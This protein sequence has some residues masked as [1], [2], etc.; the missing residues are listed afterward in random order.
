ML[1]ALLLAVAVA[2][3]A[4]APSA[5]PLK[6][7]TTVKSGPIC[8]TL[9]TTVLHT[10]QGL[11]INDKIIESSKP[12]L[13]DMAQAWAPNSL[14]GEKFDQLQAQWGNAPAGTH[15][16]D[17]AGLILGAQHIYK[18]ATGLVHN[19]QIIDNL[20]DDPARFPADPKTDVDRE[21]ALLKAQLQSVADQQRK[22]LNVLYGMADTFNMQ[23]LIAHGDGT[24]GAINAGGKNGQVS[25]ND[26]DVSFQDP[27]SGPDRGR[28]GSPKDPTVDTDPAISQKSLGALANSP[29]MRFY[30]G[31][32]EEQQATAQAEGDLSQTVIQVVN[33]CK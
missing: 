17:N 8:S 28:I 1:Q 23:D 14:A 4:P 32:V 13:V 5:S 31:V 12:V 18:V 2:Q 24:Q 30:T 19:L 22:S 10:I 7:I 15:N 9:T 29:M 6:T 21:A 3:A 33:Q 11:Q 25:H 20:L 26:Q 16:V 27:I